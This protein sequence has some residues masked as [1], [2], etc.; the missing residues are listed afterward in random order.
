MF[1]EVPMLSKATKKILYNMDTLPGSSG[2]PVIFNTGLKGEQG[3][4]KVIGVHRGTPDG[5]TMN[6]ATLL[7][8]INL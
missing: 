6:E 4:C 7:K 1:S 8:A 5:T 2:S 3:V